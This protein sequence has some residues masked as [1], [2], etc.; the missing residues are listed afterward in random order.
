MLTMG[1]RTDYI[2]VTFK[3][4]RN[5]LLGGGLWSLLYLS[6]NTHKKREK[7]FCYSENLY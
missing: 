2:L 6:I 1:Q 5:Y 3:Y 7:Y 4:M